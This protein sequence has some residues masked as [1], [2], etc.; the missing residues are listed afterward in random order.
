MPLN[1]EQYNEIMRI[2]GRRHSEAFAEQQR[3]QEEAE[4][5]LPAITVIGEQIAELS[6][7][8]MR[9]KLS[10]RDAEAVELHRQRTLLLDRKREMLK[11]SGFGA[12]YLEL[13]FSCQKC[14]DTGYVGNEKCTCFKLLETELLNRESGL[15]ALLERENFGS[16]DPYIYD[17]E[18]MIPELKPRRMTQYGYMTEVIMDSVRSFVDGFDENGGNILMMGP[19]GTGKTFLGNCIAKALIDRQHTVLY[20]RAG[21]MIN[22]FS[23]RD[24]GRTGADSLNARIER[25]AESELLLIDDLGTEFV[26]DYSRTRIYEVISGRLSGG[27]STIIST[28]LSLNQLSNVYG[29]RVTSRFIGGYRL[30]PFYGSD[31][32]IKKTGGK[33]R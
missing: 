21:D 10:H 32:R 31:L 14:G 1:R 28:N 25:I 9:A 18:I 20:E 2:I 12:D 15:P 16:F 7:A 27:L 11:A 24:F 29:E 8:E 4:R 30:L 22:A 6:T 23:A 17:D 5:Q 19:P 33:I 13:K 3:R 26:N